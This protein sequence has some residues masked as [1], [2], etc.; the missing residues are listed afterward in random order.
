[1]GEINTLNKF[2]VGV[3][4]DMVLIGRLPMGPISADDALLLAAYL[5]SMAEMNT[6]TKFEDVLKAVQNC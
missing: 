1:M 5:V 4:R 6:E 3:Q 2:F